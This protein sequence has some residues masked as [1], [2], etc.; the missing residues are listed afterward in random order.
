VI[1]VLRIRGFA[2]VD[3]VAESL[4][5][6]TETVALVLASL[7]EQG[8]AQFFEARGLYKLTPAGTENHVR[9]LSGLMVDDT[10]RLF[11]QTYTPFLELNSTFK[12]LCTRWQ[13]R[14][15]SPNDHSDA[16]YD[17]RCIAELGGL[18]ARSLEVLEGFASASRRF[19]LYAHRLQ[20][21]FAR[22]ESG[23]NRMFTGVMCGSFHDV[24]MELHEDL[25]QLLGIDRMQEG[26]F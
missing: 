15:G 20:A 5:S 3:G 14:D 13:T 19:V 18:L 12:E 2:N 1:H 8:S 7:V 22:L 4:G 25:V 10:R 17:S 23:D 26:S 9:W 16:G 11:H 21:A 6:P 24:W